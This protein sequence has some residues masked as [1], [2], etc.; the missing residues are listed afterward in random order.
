MEVSRSLSVV[1]A[2]T[3]KKIGRSLFRIVPLYHFMFDREKPTSDEQRLQRLEN[4]P[5]KVIFFWFNFG[6]TTG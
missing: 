4:T 5:E 6:L 3:V 2:R 1:R